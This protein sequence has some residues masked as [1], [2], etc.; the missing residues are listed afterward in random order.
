MRKHNGFTIVELIATIS[1]LGIIAAIAIPA[2]SHWLPKQ[3]LRSAARDLYTNMQLSKM[4]A[5]K[6][7]AQWA[8]VFDN[9]GDLGRYYICSDDGANDTWDGPAAMGGDD[10]AER[11][12]EFAIYKSGITY[13]CGN[14]THDLLGGGG[15]PADT[16]AYASDV[17]VFNPKGTSN[18]G[19]VYLHNQEN[20]IAYGVGT[21]TTGVIRLFKWNGNEWD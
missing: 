16:I 11:S 4:G 20:T 6:S 21:L 17:A 18:G 1:V 5:I 14:A 3:R 9:S 12:I 2:F 15:P 7:N 13:G 19:Y 10:V 8:I